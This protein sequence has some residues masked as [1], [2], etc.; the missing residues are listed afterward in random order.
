MEGLCADCVFWEALTEPDHEGLLFINYTGL[1]KCSCE[2][3]KF[4]DRFQD[5]CELDAFYYYD[6]DE[7]KAGFYPAQHFGCI[8]FKARP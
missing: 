3:F 7:Y 4:F 6:Y 2:K 8:H 5:P 1:G